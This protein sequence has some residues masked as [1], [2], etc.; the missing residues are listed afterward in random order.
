[1]AS[2]RVMASPSSSASSDV[3]RQSSAYA[4]AASC[5]QTE[6]L[7][8]VSMDHLL[9]GFC[10]QPPFPLPLPRNAAGTTADVV[11]EIPDGAGSGYEDAAAGADGEVTL[12]EFLARTGA[13][14]E[15]DVGVS[16][17]FVVD[18]AIGGR[19]CQQE[20]QLPLENPMLGFGSALESGGRRAR[21]RVVL[22]DPVDK[23]VLR[24][25]KRMIKNRESAARSRERK[26]AYTVEL[27][28]LVTRLEEENVTLVREQEEQHK[29]RFQQL[30]VNI[31]PVNESRKPLP[32]LRRT[33]SMQW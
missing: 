27:E 17:G 7:G 8:S 30:M 22:D 28:S 16:T 23:V 11:W 33:H 19:F 10:A 24:R 29:M 1:M 9:R 15:E 13:V 5:D 12:E 4:S 26:Q 18:P 31:I 6:A 32:V 3:A 14:R 20:Q 21:K 25:Q 2:P